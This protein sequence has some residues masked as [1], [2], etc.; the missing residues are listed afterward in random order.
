V[1]NSVVVYAVRTEFDDDATRDR[2]ARHLGVR[3][4]RVP[5]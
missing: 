1:P 3:V 2:T 5:D 4:V